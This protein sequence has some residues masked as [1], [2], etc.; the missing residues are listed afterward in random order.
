MIQIGAFGISSVITYEAERTAPGNPQGNTVA[1]EADAGTEG[2][3][4]NMPFAEFT[5]KRAAH[6]IFHSESS[7]PLHWRVDSRISEW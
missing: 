4:A 3:Q 5:L 7:W 6:V 1:A 2:H